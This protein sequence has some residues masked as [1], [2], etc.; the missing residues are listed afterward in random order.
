MSNNFQ[1]FF[2]VLFCCYSCS[3]AF[4]VIIILFRSGI[5]SVLLLFFFFGHLHESQRGLQKKRRFGSVMQSKACNMNLLHFLYD[6]SDVCLTVIESNSIKSNHDSWI[7]CSY[8][9][10]LLSLSLSSF[11]IVHG[12]EFAIEIV[13][14]LYD[15]SGNRLKPCAHLKL[16]AIG[17]GQLFLFDTKNTNTKC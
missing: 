12:N 3:I 14:G 8:I 2:F 10:S 6:E 17:K 16:D 15:F 7:M 1:C 5:S 11:C 13:A 9:C 4:T